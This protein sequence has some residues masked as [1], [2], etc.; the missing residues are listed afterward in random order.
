M[1]VDANPI[2]WWLDSE[3]T[4][5]EEDICGVADI[6]FCQIFGCDDIIK[7][8]RKHTAGLPLVLTIH[9]SSVLLDRMNMTEISTGVY[10]AT[11]TPDTYTPALC[12][13]KT[14]WT[15]VQ[16]GVFQDQTL[17]VSGSAGGTVNGTL[18]DTTTT[19]TCPRSEKVTI[20]L[21]ATSTLISGGPIT[22][23]VT[24]ILKLGTT[25][26]ATL[27]V[28][29]TDT[30][31]DSDFDTFDGAYDRI[32]LLGV[33]SSGTGNWAL[34]ATV[35]VTREKI[36]VK[37]DCVEIKTDVDCTVLIKYTNS[38]N[39]AG[40]VYNSSPAQEFYLRIPAQF[41]QEDNPQ[42][43]EDSELSSGTIVTRRQAI[44]EKR[45]LEIGYMPNYMHKKLQLVLMHETITIDGTQW[46]RRD[47]YEAEPVRRYPLKKAQVWLTKYNSILKNTL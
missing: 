31:N 45:L 4:F 18:F 32:E 35:V 6:E 12:D 38:E 10:E 20:K 39:F 3:E 25:T 46:K 22:G 24:A 1:T 43:E 28:S 34:N 7:V 13:K 17:N 8:Q 40:L 33:R 16:D 41:W 21:N 30:E 9:D 37:S 2:Q 27:N 26:V 5:N 47:T 23:S 14:L 11:I 44:V 29:L 19:L 15:I 42:E 36:I